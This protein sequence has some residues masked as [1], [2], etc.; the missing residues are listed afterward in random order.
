MNLL[1]QSIETHLREKYRPVLEHHRRLRAMG[2]EAYLAN[3]EAMG[4]EPSLPRQYPQTA[5]HI[6]ALR[7][8][9]LL[10]EAKIEA[11]TQA[12]A[13]ELLPYV[14]RQREASGGVGPVTDP[15]MEEASF[16]RARALV[17]LGTQALHFE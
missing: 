17:W 4:R 12:E 11:L 8:Q 6:L 7:D 1:L 5:G 16:R 10:D 9:V 2:D 13:A 3:H 14:L 15:E